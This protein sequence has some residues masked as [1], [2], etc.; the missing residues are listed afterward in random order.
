[1]VKM[2]NLKIYVFYNKNLKLK[3]NKKLQQKNI[4]YL[5]INF[6]TTQDL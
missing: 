6:K 3:W 1:M 4:K 2:V 5:K